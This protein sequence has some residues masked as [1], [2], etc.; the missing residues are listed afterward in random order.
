MKVLWYQTGLWNGR[1]LPLFN[2]P[3]P[4]IH[5]IKYPQVEELRNI[6]WQE[7]ILFMILDQKSKNNLQLSFPSELASQTL[8]QGYNNRLKAVPYKIP[9]LSSSKTQ[10]NPSLGELPNG[11]FLH[12]SGNKEILISSWILPRGECLPPSSQ[13]RTVPLL[14]LLLH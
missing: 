8:T 5:F 13:Q 2:L 7:H 11:I 3:V 4:K 12:I 6:K 14:S 9:H 10:S 1:S